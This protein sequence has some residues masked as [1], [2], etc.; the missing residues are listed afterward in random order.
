LRF[1]VDA[2]YRPY[3]FSVSN[4]LLNGASQQNVSAA[5]WQFPFLAQYRLNV[6]VVR[7]FLEGG[8]SFNHLSNIS[9]AANN[10]GSG[11]GTL[12]A[13]SHAAVVL[14]VGV[15]VKLPL[16][17]V[18]GELRYSHQTSA[19]FAQI[20]NLNQAEFLLGVHF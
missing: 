9:A 3:S 2:L 14:G 7:P 6:P 18:S 15:D 5:D 10:I 8:L 17:R 20:S 11:P 16:I 19:D 4:L 12:V 13:Q 1:E